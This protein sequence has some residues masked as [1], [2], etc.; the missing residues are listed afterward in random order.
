MPKIAFQRQW[1][2]ALGRCLCVPIVAALPLAATA[3]D[4]LL[5]VDTNANRIVKLDPNSGAIVNGSFIVDANSTTT[6]DFQT[7]RAAVQVG[8]QIWV[9]DQSPNINA[10]YRF[11]L[12][13]SFLGRIG[14]NVAGGGLSN[15][16]GMRVIGN[17]VYVVNAGTANGAPGPAILQFDFAGNATGSFSTAVAGIGASPWDVVAY[18]G[19]LLVSDGTSRGLQLFSMSGTHLGAFT[20]TQINNIPQQMF[21]RANGNV[22]MS[23]NGST[24][25]GSFGLYELGSNGSVLRQWTGTPGL[26]VRGVYELPDGRLLISEA[27]GASATRGLGTIDPSGPANSGNFSLIV[28]NWNGGWISPVTVVPE[29]GRWALMAAGLVLLLPRLRR[30]ASLQSGPSS[31][32]THAA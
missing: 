1:S 16:R 8:E 12:G 18:N 15:V 20:P 11:D 22:L 5:G 32:P 23:A 24:P 25:T 28:G 27:G 26:G 17:T 4:F 2:R 31:S 19:N 7:L 6:Y 29:P 30:A 14:G 10:I 9:S 13:G 3:Q 21:V